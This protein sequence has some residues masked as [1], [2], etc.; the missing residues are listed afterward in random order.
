MKNFMAVAI[1]FLNSVFICSAQHKN[2]LDSL[3]NVSIEKHIISQGTKERPA[4]FARDNTSSDFQFSKSITDKVNFLSYSLYTKKELSKGIR[5]LRLLPVI[6]RGDL[7][8]ITISD[9]LV[10][11]KGN[12]IS[13][14]V[15][16][17][18]TYQYQYSCSKQY[19]ELL[20]VK[21]F[22]I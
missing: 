14:S 13:I 11:K 18:S 21:A 7:L 5:V 15:G 6:L 22:G 19:W 12:N 16:S 1:C 4:V 8:T 17:G 3:I 2:D 20:A 9:D 10:T